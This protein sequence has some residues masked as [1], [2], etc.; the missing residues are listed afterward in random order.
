MGLSVASVSASIVNSLTPMQQK[1][2]A[3][4]AQGHRGVSVAEKLGIVPETISRWHRLPSFEAALNQSRSGSSD[5][6]P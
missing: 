3:L 1:A 2:I 4:L 6:H 5:C